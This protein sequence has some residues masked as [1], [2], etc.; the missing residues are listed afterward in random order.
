MLCYNIMLYVI[1]IC[2]V[3]VMVSQPGWGYILLE[4]AASHFWGTLHLDI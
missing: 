3:H 4:E 1:I 2:Y